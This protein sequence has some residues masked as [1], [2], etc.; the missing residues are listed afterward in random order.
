MGGDCDTVGSIVGQMA[1]SIYGFDNDVFQLYREMQDFTS[2]RFEIFLLAYK[3]TN[4]ISLE[5]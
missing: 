5:K 3:L 2:K 4:R 1:G